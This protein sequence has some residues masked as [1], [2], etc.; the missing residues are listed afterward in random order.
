MGE[1]NQLFLAIWEDIG[2]MGAMKKQVQPKKHAGK[3]KAVVQ[4]RRKKIIKAIAEGKTQKEAGIEAGLNPNSARQQVGEILAEPCVQKTFLE[5]LNEK[6]PDDFHSNVYRE[7]MEANKVISANVIAPNGE[8]M[9]DAN[10]MTKDFIEV[11][12]HPTRI[13]AADSVSK[14]K[15]LVVDKK[16]VGLDERAVELI[17]GA[18]P[19]EV[20][21]AIRKELFEGEQ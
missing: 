15:G 12:D 10:S 11:P 18:L 8:G 13:K 2:I 6:I 1:N 19:K 21:D 3:T 7:G 4:A 16:Q 9:K 17:L 20:G 14:L 5:I